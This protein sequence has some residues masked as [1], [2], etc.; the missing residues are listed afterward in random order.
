MPIVT[1]SEHGSIAIPPD[2]RQ[3]YGLYAG[4]KVV[5]V[6]Y[7]DALVLVPAFADPVR[8]ATGMLAGCP[9][10]TE[11]LLRERAKELLQ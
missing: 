4:A 7:G 3:K 10:L 2:L 6:D 5:T 9:S 1:V 11:A 8:Q